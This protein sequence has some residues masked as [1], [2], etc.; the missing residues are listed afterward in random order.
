[1]KK[2]TNINQYL[3]NN[4]SI[5]TPSQLNPYTDRSPTRRKLAQEDQIR[6]G[7]SNMTEIKRHDTRETIAI[8]SFIG[9]R[10]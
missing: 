7:R 5:I 6:S 3:A 10:S 4:N 8:N 9:D 2:Y 1:M